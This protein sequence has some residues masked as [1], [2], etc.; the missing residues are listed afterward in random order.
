M[1]SIWKD[2]GA[3]QGGDGSWITVYVPLVV[4]AGA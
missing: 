3:R 2:E 4:C 1:Q